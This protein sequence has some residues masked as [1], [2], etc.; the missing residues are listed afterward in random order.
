MM[1]LKFKKLVPALAL[2][3]LWVSSSLPAKHRESF[4]P[5]KNPSSRTQNVTPD[6]TYSGVTGKFDWPKLW[7]ANTARARA[8]RAPPI[9]SA[10][11]R[12]IAAASSNTIDDH[13]KGRKHFQG[14]WKSITFGEMDGF[15]A[16]GLFATSLPVI[17]DQYIYIDTTSDPVQIFTMYGT[18]KYPRGQDP[19]DPPRSDMP[20][21]A[22][23]PEVTNSYSYFF[24]SEKELVNFYNPPLSGPVDPILPVSLGATLKLLDKDTLIAD[25]YSNSNYTFG[26]IWQSPILYKKIEKAPCDTLNCN[27]NDPVLLFKYYADLATFQNPSTN[28][29]AGGKWYVGAKKAKKIMEKF[30]TCGFTK[31]TPIRKLRITNFTQ[32]EAAGMSD[33]AWTTIYT[34]DPVTNE[35]IFSNV[36]PGSTP[37]ISGATGQFSV[38]NG[39]YPNGVSV[40]NCAANPTLD[41]RH[42]DKGPNGSFNDLFNSF[43]L[44]LDTSTSLAALAD[45]L[46]GLVDV[47]PGVFVEVTYKV[48]SSM[49]YPAFVA[50]CAAYFNE[51]VKAATHQADQ[52][53]TYPN[54]SRIINTFTE[55]KSG[56]QAG[57]LG[58]TPNLMRANQGNPNIVYHNMVDIYSFYSAFGLFNLNNVLIN[59][60][61]PLNYSNPILEYDV[62]LG[63]YI[64]NVHNL[65]F[66]IQG[67][68]ESDQL[69]PESIGYPP[70]IPGPGRAHFVGKV[71]PG[72]ISNGL[73]FATSPDGYMLLGFPG[74]TD[75]YK[76]NGYYFG[77]V[78][79][80]LTA[81]KT[82]GYMFLTDMFFYDPFGLSLTGEYAPENPNTSK[83][84]RI[85]REG[86]S[87]LY[88]EIMKWFNA[89]YPYNVDENGMPRT[90]C[91]KIIIDIV[92][93]PGG[94]PLLQ[95]FSEFM[96]SDRIAFKG[97]TVPKDPRGD[98]IPFNDPNF[99]TVNNTNA[100]RN[101]TS[102][103]DYVSLNEKL[104]PGS[105]FKGTKKHPKEVIILDD[106]FS[107]SAGDIGPNMFI[108]DNDD[109]YLG[110]HVQM[111]L[112]GCIDGREFGFS[113][114]GAQFPVNDNTELMTP[115]GFPASPFTMIRDDGSVYWQYGKSGVSQYVQA[116]ATRPIRT[117]V[118]GT[119]GGA[120]LPISFEATVFQDLG[121]TPMTRPPLQGWTEP[122]P[123]FD[124]PTTWRFLYLEQAIEIAK[125]PVKIRKQR[126]HEKTKPPKC[127]K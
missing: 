28:P 21:L 64:V 40:C 8:M 19:L 108:G 94:Q 15:G 57:T 39:T 11:R 10:R 2:I 99:L 105:I 86:L 88:A 30:L 1:Y 56:L 59:S 55:L 92:S 84:P 32:Y 7:F 102:F 90:P 111:N 68:L 123:D 66:G 87:T 118:S 34:G 36:T 120:P 61:Y 72:D 14:W 37:T 127:K 41:V 76:A 38:L 49:E 104:Y 50:A 24:Q 60:P 53:Y 75:F 27:W 113:E 44:N 25:S 96:G 103:F 33:D 12:P 106:I 125:G 51:T 89:A 122:P 45:P 20:P 35:G 69:D 16:D 65:C 74:Q 42:V 80:Q 85:C 110:S 114:F 70:L 3:A 121:L 18:E 48:D 63:N 83:N 82:I 95:Q 29:K 109:G 4:S 47:P 117:P 93:N 98:L 52:P 77:Q 100:Q 46:T 81:G 116:D 23:H 115:D 43:L 5:H 9:H 71:I 79:P 67:T 54:S 62:P 78:N 6:L 126:N 17:C 107:F 97:F 119:D 124:D 73:N 26:E 101:C 22:E 13:H 58:Q 91:E 31:K 112:V